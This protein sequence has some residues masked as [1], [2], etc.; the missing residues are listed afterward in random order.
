M[1]KEE[2]LESGSEPDRQ[3]QKDAPEASE[4]FWVVLRDT[5]NKTGKM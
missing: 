1:G 3:I 4:L 2:E 5:Q